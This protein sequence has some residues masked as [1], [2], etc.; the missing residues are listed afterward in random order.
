MASFHDDLSHN[1]AKFHL[2]PNSVLDNQAHSMA[3]L[4]GLLK[5]ESLK[6]SLI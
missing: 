1:D 6:L 3:F 2:S 5:N 4:F